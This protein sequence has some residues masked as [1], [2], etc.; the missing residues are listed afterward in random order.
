MDPNANIEE[1]RKIYERCFS[2]KSEEGDLMR[3][4]ELVCA[5]DAWMRAGGFPPNAWKQG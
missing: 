3:L 2:N 5:L 4:S 1:Q